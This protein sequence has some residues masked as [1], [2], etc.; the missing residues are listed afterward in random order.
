MGFLFTLDLKKRIHALEELEHILIL[1]QGEVRYGHSILPEAYEHVGGR[2]KKPFQDFLKDMAGEMRKKNGEQQI[3]IARKAGKKYL[4]DSG[5]L[6]EDME[7]LFSFL[8][9]LGYLDLKMQNNSME[10][11]QKQLEQAKIHAMTKYREKGQ[12]FRC[13]GAVSGIFFIL[14]LL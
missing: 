1:L 3:T 7:G 4:A 13:L 11:Y 5:M 8:S 12:L 9:D 14:L 2:V 6:K 10:L